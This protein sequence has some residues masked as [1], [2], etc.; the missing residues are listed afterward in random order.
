M[1]SFTECI[2]KWSERVTHCYLWSDVALP[3]NYWRKINRIAMDMTKWVRVCIWNTIIQKISICYGC[4]LS[5]A[6]KIKNKHKHVHIV[7]PCFKN[8]DHDLQPE[9]DI[10]LNLLTKLHL[11]IYLPFGPV[12]FQTFPFAWVSVC[13]VALMDESSVNSLHLVRVWKSGKDIR[14]TQ[15]LEE[16][17]KHTPGR[18]E[19]DCRPRAWRFRFNQSSTFTLL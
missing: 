7:L 19:L 3:E 8:T 5:F 11:F 4:M 2:L 12:E 6:F 14:K 18:L 1:Y 15:R 17:K 16:L 10:F 9:D 13:K